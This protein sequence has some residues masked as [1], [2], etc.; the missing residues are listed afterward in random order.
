[1]HDNLIAVIIFIVAIICIIAIVA[2]RMH[3][4][5]NIVTVEGFIDIYY[6]NIFGAIQDVVSLLSIDVDD[7]ETK[8]EYEK[9]II[10][11]TVIK[12][13]EN[14]DEFGINSSLFKL[15]DKDV[16]T[17]M[18][19]DILYT[20]KVQIFFSSITEKTVK[21]KPELYDAEVIEAFENAQ[22]VLGETSDECEENS[23]IEENSEQIEKDTNVSD[24]EKNKENEE[25]IQEDEAIV[26]EN[27]ADSIPEI[28]NE[29]NEAPD[30]DLTPADPDYVL[31][32][33][34]GL[35]GTDVDINT[36]E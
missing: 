33:G 4:N 31:E 5:N 22:P 24:N 18:L 27:N 19:Y 11:T 30:N 17:D 34:E 23:T 3:K 25:V 13:E 12:L 7:F 9:A 2:Y 6:N 21:I 35:D 32:E 14:C 8:E 16:L 1:M 28:S 10:S 26:G 20:N 36:L 29:E 15:V